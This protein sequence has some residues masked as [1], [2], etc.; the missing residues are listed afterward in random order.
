MILDL[1]LLLFVIVC[2]LLLLLLLFLLFSLFFCCS[3]KN[4]ETETYGKMK[5]TMQKLCF[6]QGF[7]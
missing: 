7:F 3:C 1:V 5:A 6:I 4:E 2:S